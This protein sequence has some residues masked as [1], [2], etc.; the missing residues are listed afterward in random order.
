MANDEDDELVL[1]V[2]AYLKLFHI[3]LLYKIKSPKLWK[4]R[5]AFGNSHN[6]V[7]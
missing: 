5:Q 1:F 4:E 7:V 3:I 6:F 2:L